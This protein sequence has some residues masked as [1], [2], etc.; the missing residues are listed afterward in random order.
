[1]GLGRPTGNVVFN[2][3]KGEYS[4]VE[5]NERNSYIL[6]NS[7]A[8]LA[9]EPR[10]YCGNGQSKPFVVAKYVKLIKELSLLNF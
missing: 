10:T 9:S 5:E 2:T 4:P 7:D 8:F 1:M 6:P 3:K